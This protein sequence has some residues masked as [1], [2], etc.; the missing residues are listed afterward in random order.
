LSTTIDFSLTGTGQNYSLYEE[1][2]IVPGTLYCR[3]PDSTIIAPLSTALSAIYTKYTTISAYDTL[4]NKIN[5]LGNEINLECINFDV[6][7]DVLQ[8]ETSNHLIF[9]KIRFNTVSNT[10]AGSITYSYIYRGNYP[11]FEK[12][13]NTWFN[14]TQK[15][16]IVCQT[17]LFTTY[18][19]N[20]D[21]LSA[22][23]YKSIYPKIYAVD[24]NYPQP[25]QIYPYTADQNLS[26]SAVSQYSLSGTN[27]Q[28]NIVEV[29]KPIL[30]FNSLTDIYDLTYLCKDAANAFYTVNI[31]FKYINGVL[32]I[33]TTTLYTPSSNTLHQNFGTYGLSSTFVLPSLSTYSILGN[34]IGYINAAD[35]T[36]TF[37]TVSLTGNFL[38]AQT[39][40]TSPLS[41]LEAQ[42]SLTSPLTGFAIVL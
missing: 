39:S 6:Y 7:Y 12:F 9:D 37:N 25:K 15:Q 38:E 19:N 2:N 30:T 22:T 31:K 27:I 13:S 1:R 28:L 29:E 20:I 42:I 11:H 24:L 18:I 34:S 4:T 36:F 3:T 5:T 33:L 40:L 26:L 21:P 10:V 8:I 17:K 16:L 35:S 23:N 32:T 41:D 14:E